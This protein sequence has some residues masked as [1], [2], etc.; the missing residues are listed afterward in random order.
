MTHNIGEAVLVGD[1]VCSLHAGRIRGSVAVDLPRPRPPRARGSP[2][3]G[4]LYDA[5]SDLLLAEA[6]R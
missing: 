3:F 5:V 1:T 2:A 4:R 6:P